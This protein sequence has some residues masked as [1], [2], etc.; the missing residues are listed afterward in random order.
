MRRIYEPKKY[1]HAIQQGSIIDCCIA[2][3][4][5]CCKVFGLIITPRCDIANSKVTTVHYLPVVSYIDWVNVYLR[6]ICEK[7]IT[8]VIE[9][10]LKA[11]LVKGKL[12]VSILDTFSID[13]LIPTIEEKQM[14]KGNNLTEFI[15]IYVDYQ[16]IKR[17]VSTK[18]IHLKYLLDKIIKSKINDLIGNKLPSYYLIEDWENKDDMKVIC[19]RDVRRISFDIAAKIPDGLYINK[20]NQET[21]HKND[22]TSPSTYPD[23][24]LLIHAQIKSP[25][26]EHILQAFIHN[27][28]RIGVDRVDVISAD[29][30][31]SKY[32][33][34]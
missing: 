21:L 20:L 28:G 25:F 11:I 34:K 13:S 33:T 23:D 8:T 3:S 32:N 4:Y 19:L 6:P 9:K 17:D 16:T 5:E 10:K 18:D 27:F 31:I 22:L 7:E 30:L 12:D 29:D 1:L 14:L 26:L 2:E 24:L 15:E